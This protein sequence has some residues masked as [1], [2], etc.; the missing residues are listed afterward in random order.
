M[1]R[2]KVMGKPIGWGWAIAALLVLVLALRGCGASRYGTYR[3]AGRYT[4]GGFTYQRGDVSSVEINW[5]SADVKIVQKDSGTLRVSETGNL[6]KAQQLHWYLDGDELIIQYCESG[7][8][9]RIPGRAKELTVEVPSGIDLTVNIVSGD[10]TLPAGQAYDKVSINS[11]SGTVSADD[12]TAD[13]LEINTV[14][15]DVSIGHFYGD[16]TDIHTTSG[17]V[18]VGLE[19]CD[20]AE[21][22]SISGDV[23]LTSLP[24][25][26]ATISYSSLSGRFSG[27]G[28]ATKDKDY[29]FGAG[30][31]KIEVGT[32]SG[33]L[34]VR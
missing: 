7:Y 11:V 31:T 12:F 17:K 23:T 29:V 25:Q 19:A 5:I 30:G 3:N 21:I 2:I 6:K 26:G 15:G 28:Y 9:G 10:V 34:K 16:K 4:P 24:A 14:S 8:R 18:E 13:K 22:A 20:K 32:T 1:D 33:N 27:E